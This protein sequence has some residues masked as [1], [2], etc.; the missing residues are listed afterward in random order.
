MLTKH[1][2]RSLLLLVLILSL[3]APGIRAANILVVTIEDEPLDP[4]DA[5]IV[6]FLEGLGHTVMLIDDGENE[7]TTE[8]AALEADIV[9]I[10]ESVGSGDIR[11]EITEIETPMIIAEMW[12]WD[13]MGLSTKTGDG[14]EDVTSTDIDIVTPNHFLAA[15]LS[16][17]VPVLTAAASALG[18]GIVGPEAT[19][20]ATAT[21]ADNVT[22]DVI[23]VYEKGAA[24]PVAPADG[25]PPVAA[26]MRIGFGFHENTY[27]NWNDNTYALLEAAINYALGVRPGADLAS[28]PSP[29]DGAVDVSRDSIL[30]WTPGESAI[31]HDVYFGTDLDDVNLA[32][33]AD[34]RAVLVSEGQDPNTYD[35]TVPL[36]LGQ[37]YYWRVDEVNAPPDSTVFQGY[38]W[39]FT[40]EP[41]AHP[42]EAMTVT[43]NAVPSDD[44]GPDNTINGSGLDGSDQH[45]TQ[46]DDMWL[47]LPPDGESIWLQYEFDRVYKLTELWVWNYN[48]LF[49]LA[50]GFGLKD[51]TVEY[52]VDG[53]DW[54]AL[55][56]FEFAQA[57]AGESYAHN[58]T[59][60]LKGI[61]AKYVRLTI[62]SNWG[63]LPQYGLSEIRFLYIP[64]Y[65]REPLP[66][67]GQNDLAPNVLLSWRAGREAVAHEVSFSTDLDAVVDGAALVDTVSDT[68]YDP[69]SL[70]FGVKYYWKIIEVNEAEAVTSWA[71][72]VWDF[73]IQEYATIDDFES[74]DDDENRIYE[75]WADG[76]VNETSSTV[77]YFEAPFAEKTIT[78]EGSQSMPL[79][80]SNADSPWYSE[81]ERTFA[82]PQNWA[83]NGADTLLVHFRG[84]PVAFFERADGSIVIGA[85]GV[86]IWSTADEFRFVHKTLTGDASIVARVDSV[87]EMDPWTKA[88]VMIRESLDAGAKFA[89]IYITSGN[90]CRYQARRA[91]SVD[92]VSD[93]SVAT[94]E[95]IAIT[96]PYW[97]K[98][99]RSGNEFSGF[100]SADGSSWTPM[101][102]NPQI[103]SMLGS[104]H[105][106][107]AVTSHNAGNPTLA[108]FS[109]VTTTGNVT[110]AWEV[111]TI[112][113][114]QPSNNPDQMYVAVQDSAG[115]T[116]LVA[117]PDP[118]AT[119]ISEWQAWAIPLDTLNAAGVDVSSIKAMSIGAGDRDNP[120]AAGLGTLYID[121]V[122]VGHPAATQ[123]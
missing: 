9:F 91:A 4:E 40:T 83:A 17:T 82:A 62:N 52:S 118:E 109:A 19:V 8:A 37:T 72:D 114:A 77:G 18:A 61:A 39:A 45:S 38:V 48:V 65:A 115:H 47:G 27:A 58:T 67:S 86:D 120:Q 104:I 108:E 32:S 101:S 92:A 63:V 57:P 30:T 15:G 66:A 20:I 89:G 29:A 84:N 51:V 12:G 71:G 5:L 88:G 94:P 106:G 99:E 116:A 33:R 119:G 44:S 107:L 11:T 85:A 68:S 36:E 80:Y 117:H 64:T 10:S 111:A 14:D 76:W 13:E 21:L 110:G 79:Q 50:L 74:Y 87:L 60:D 69:G 121:D 6:E 95:Q 96:T 23:F 42:I 24:L 53:A 81:A 112:G 93:T 55:G 31:A 25:S 100:Y 59:I 56:D 105:I 54:I 1:V 28:D 22:Y 90:G 41:L 73:T 123:Q 49:E 98:L 3:A 97:V 43:T 2:I 16:G 34:P 7:A 26:E 113:V 78:H 75:T 103:I 70:D 46:P 35:P 102:W 122:L